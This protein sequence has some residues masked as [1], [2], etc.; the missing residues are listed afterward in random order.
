M[1]IDPP[2][3]TGLSAPHTAKGR[4][5]RKLLELLRVHERDGMLPTSIRF[6]FYEPVAAGAV[7]KA[8]TGKRRADQN[9]IDAVTQLRE[10]VAGQLRQLLGEGD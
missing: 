4:L 8:A 6:L 7:P 1:T 2:D 10:R 9:T 5:Q 3:E